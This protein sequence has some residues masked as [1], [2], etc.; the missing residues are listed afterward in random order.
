MGVET[1]LTGLS[2]ETQKFLKPV[3]D[4]CDKCFYE[5]EG[6]VG[7]RLVL[8]TTLSLGNPPTIQEAVRK[9]E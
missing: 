8:L 1:R 6:L 7:V 4:K 3:G 9:V 5:N 2:Q